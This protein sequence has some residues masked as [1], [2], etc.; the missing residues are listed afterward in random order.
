[1]NR[2]LLVTLLLIIGVLAITSIMLVNENNKLERRLESVKH[3]LP[4]SQ[5]Q[6]DLV[7]LEGAIAYQIENQWSQPS[8][9]REKLGDVIQDIMVIL[10]VTQGM[11][12]LSK[13]EKDS[14]DIFYRKL[15][16]YPADNM[17]KPTNELSQDEI[18]K[19]K[20]L[21]QALRDVE[22]GVGFSNTQ[23]WDSFMDKLMKLL[24][25]I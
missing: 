3:L 21:R 12:V 25:N 17:V 8:H 11:N 16:D 15:S 19:L 14:L 20:Q 18:D 23:H 1:M 22:W 9:V 2:K 7:Q 6:W 24:P 4:F 5:I 10:E 13:Q